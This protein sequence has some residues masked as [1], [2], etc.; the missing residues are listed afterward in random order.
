[1]DEVIN[2]IMEIE[3]QCAADV[4]QAETEYSKR[5]EEYKHI[6]E[7]NKNK[8]HVRILFAESTG[9]NQAL[10]KAKEQ[11]EAVSAAFREDSENRLQDPVLKE[12]IKKDIISILLES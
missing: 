12:A 4:D 11:T 9:L 7:E 1:M 6:L 5:I 10:Q 3:R 8:E 2:R